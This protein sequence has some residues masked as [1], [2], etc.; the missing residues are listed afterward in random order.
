MSNRFHNKFH[1]VNHHSV[2]SPDQK[3]PDAGYDPIASFDS[4]FQGEFYS[5]GDV[6]T[7][8]NLSAGIDLT[9]D[10]NALIRNNL[11][12]GYDALVKNDLTVEEDFTVL[13]T[14][15]RLES[16]VSITSSIDVS[17]V[18][19]GPALSINQFNNEPVAQF[20]NSG[21]PALYVSREG[22]VGVNTDIPNEHLTING[23]LSARDNV[24]VAGN[25]FLS[26]N[27]FIDKT[28]S[29]KDDLLYVD[30]T[31]DKVGINTKFPNTELTVVGSISSTE[32]LYVVGNTFLG[33]LSSQDTTTINGNLI[34]N[35]SNSLHSVFV[36]NSASFPFVVN[37]TG[38]VGIGTTTPNDELTIVGDVSATGRLNVSPVGG[39]ATLH[40][41]NSRVGINTETPNEELTVVGSISSSE[42][43]FASGHNA[44]SVNWSYA[45][46]NAA[47]AVSGTPYQIISTKTN[48]LPGQNT[49][50]LN[51][52]DHVIFPRDV[53]IM[54]NL[55]ASGSAT[56]VYTQNLEVHDSLIYLAQDNTSNLL[57]IGIVSHFTDAIK[58]FQ[59]SGLVRRAGG[60]V[61]GVWT[62]FS[63][64]T[65]EPLTGNNL[66]W[67]DT[68][69]TL[70]TLSANI[71]T[72]TGHSDEWTSV[73]ST[74]QAASANWQTAYGS[75]AGLVIFRTAS[76]EALPTTVLPASANDIELQATSTVMITS[77]ENVFKGAAYTLTNT[78]SFLITLSSSPRLFV[79][80]GTAWTS[81]MYSLSTAF[82]QLPPNYSCSLRVHGSNT[83]AVW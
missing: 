76:A 73:Y 31:T 78:S 34:V 69:I 30:S 37:S 64:L 16:L 49:Y 82:L 57:D 25:S 63:G 1:R 65:T 58:G 67:S 52:P 33:N 44:N 4:P 56:F 68:N 20:L 24:I 8:E 55:T 13:G 18:G 36:Q 66:D 6:I 15:T 72:N 19:T 10:N 2:S 39:I 17:N 59:H 70:D 47:H 45:Y 3:F 60:T 22:Y 71:A 21:N 43:I 23:N 29:V 74:V 54:G 81:N 79:R 9:V 75:V 41:Q 35:N 32:N 83:V 26:G 28:L 51:F 5:E 42:T 27:S 62:L 50:A 11:T 53:E 40:A 61:P 48:S 46:N 80:N 7:T 12:V 38:L 14:N 77:F